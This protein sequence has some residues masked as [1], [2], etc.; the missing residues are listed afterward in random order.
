MFYIAPFTLCTRTVCNNMR[1]YFFWS[2]FSSLLTSHSQF[3]NI[4]SSHVN[5][6]L[7]S[8]LIICVG[9]TWCH[10]VVYFAFRIM[11]RKERRKGIKNGNSKILP[12]FVDSWCCIEYECE[13]STRPISL[14]RFVDRL[15]KAAKYL[16]CSQPVCAG[17]VTRNVRVVRTLAIELKIMSECLWL[18][19]LRV[20][21][22]CYYL[23]LSVRPIRLIQIT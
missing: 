12:F 23:L 3:R 8:H 10:S 16:Q 11:Q 14:I 13:A 21:F 2:R 4:W 19:L 15:A 1:F 18:S 9:S 20:W 5:W 7:A 22:G 6:M 17:Q